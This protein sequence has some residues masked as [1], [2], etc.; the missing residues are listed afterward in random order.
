LKGE[1]PFSK[2]ELTSGKEIH[3]SKRVSVF[4]LEG[5]SPFKK[6]EL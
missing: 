5:E 6:G 3:P 4:T 1:S 2:D